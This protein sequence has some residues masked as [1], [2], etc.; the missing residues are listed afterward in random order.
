MA[1]A[2]LYRVFRVGKTP[3]AIRAEISGERT[4]YATEGS[5][6]SLHRSGHVPGSIVSSGVNLGWGGFAITDQRVIGYRGRAKLVDVPFDLVGTGPA[7]LSL[8]STGLHVHFDLDA[9]N[10]SCG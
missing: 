10:E 2:L 5:R 7:T 8:D 6:V 9:V 1:K 4:L 3:D